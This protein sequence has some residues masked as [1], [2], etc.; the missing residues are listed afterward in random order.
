MNVSEGRDPAV[1]GALGRAAGDALLD[2]HADPDHHRAVLTL[3]GSGTEEAV[4]ALAGAALEHL[5]LSAH[6][7]AHPRFGVLDV[8]PFVPL[9]DGGSPL[10]GAADLGEALA[11]RDRFAAW[12]GTALD[13]PCFW[14]GPE[15][16]LP[17]VRRW[18][19]VDLVP[20]TGPPHPHPR[21]GA[22]AVGARHALV[23]YNLW[24]TGVGVEV[25]RA[26]AGALRGPA[27]RALGLDVGGRAQV[28]CN[29]VDPAVAGPADVYDAVRRLTGEAGGTIERSELVGLVPAAVL[30]GTARGR[31]AEL[32]LDED[33]TIEARL[34]RRPR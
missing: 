23:A 12:A 18:A 32:D 13:L 24:L 17:E 2:V 14:Y 26:V 34:R 11:A 6:H 22:C 8:V 3:G 29:L 4:R 16:S 10:A 25:A 1:L 30:G 15:R 28:S 5:D 7:G 27:V 33:R 9:D 19:F 20:D 21:A 31:W